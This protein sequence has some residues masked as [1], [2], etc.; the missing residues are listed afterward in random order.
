[1]L[2]TY[3]K[4]FAGR[5]TNVENDLRKKI[6]SGELQS[7]AKLKSR[8]KLAAEYGVALVTVERA[9]ANLIGEGLLKSEARSGTYISGVEGSIKPSMKNGTKL[10]KIAIMA[11]NGTDVRNPH[12]LE[13]NWTREITRAIQD[14]VAGFGYSSE[15]RVWYPERQPL[16]VIKQESLHGIEGF[17]IIDVHRKL[18]ETKEAV[19]Y[20][21]RHGHPVVLVT[22]DE[23]QKPVPHVFYDQTFTGYEAASQLIRLGKKRIVFFSP[24]FADWVEKRERGVRNAVDDAGE[25]YRFEVFP[26]IDER[27]AVGTESDQTAIARK[28]A[29]DFLTSDL[30]DT[31]IVA[32]NDS[33]AIGLIK[34]CAD[35]ALV[36]GKDFPL[37]SFD[38]LPTAKFMALSTFR[39]PLQSMGREAVN[40]LVRQIN[41]DFGA[42]QIRL[43][44]ELVERASTMPAQME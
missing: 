39:P 8:R 34:A 6:L 36:V 27:V 2:P 28:V 32:V 18:V 23:L 9:L 19:E 11:G 41:R 21:E 24:L 15:L 13:D 29:I 20:L 1:M 25:G 38:D 35:T 42:L 37:I 14:T 30:T 43:R 7:G 5:A 10:K 40:L 3:K 31:G 12:E 17:I 16:E 26:A 4:P 44:S 33:A 22:Y